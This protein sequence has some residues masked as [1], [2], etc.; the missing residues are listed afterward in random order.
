M[1]GSS[2]TKDDIMSSNGPSNPNALNSLVKGTVVEGK[3]VCESDIRIDGTLKGSLY[4][5]S[6]VIIG[7]TGVIDGDIQCVNAVIEGRFHGNLKVDDTLTVKE[8]AVIKGDVV[9]GKLSIVSGAIF[10][11]TCKMSGSATNAQL[12]STVKEANNGAAKT[13]K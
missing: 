4:C 3:V 1:F 13:A 5:K 9:T 10:D 11:V 6:K 8:T 7:P 12:A 2:K